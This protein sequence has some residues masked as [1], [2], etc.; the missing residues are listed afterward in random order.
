MTPQRYLLSLTVLS[1]VGVTGCGDEPSKQFADA[2]PNVDARL[3]DAALDAPAAGVVKAVS[4]RFGEIVPGATVIFQNA[5][6]STISTKTTDANG[7]ATETMLPG[8]TVNIVLEQ[9]F[10]KRKTVAFGGP[11]NE[12]ISFVG[13]KPGDV[14]RSG[15]LFAVAPM[16]S[17]QINLPTV[18][19]VS[20]I[21]IATSCGNAFL[22]NEPPFLIDLE[23]GC[24]TANMLVVMR[25]AN[26]GTLG[27]F[28]KG[29]VTIPASGA[30]EL[31]TEPLLADSTFN[32]SATNV[33]ADINSLNMYIARSAGRIEGATDNAFFQP[34]TV[35][36]TNTG[37]VQIYGATAPD[38]LAQTNY[39][40]ANG[41]FQQL[42][43]LVAPSTAYALDFAG[44]VLPW[45]DSQP[46][47]NL[48]TSEVTWTES[49]GAAP[50]AIQFR[51]TTFRQAAGFSFARTVIAPYQ[52][53]SLKI[54][55][56]PGPAAKY[57]FIADDNP[58]L[59]VAL[60]KVG[61]GYDVLRPL[62]AHPFDRSTLQGQRGRARVSY[63]NFGE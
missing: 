11:T 5:D 8:G 17:H 34:E 28:Y 61:V 7:E 22:I 18:P 3:G 63:S 32:V 47:L 60:I 45:F 57:D 15:D 38:L 55:K 56:L 39:F 30:I 19:G 35:A 10:T 2:N 12:V 13:V 46:A 59:G 20:R 48:A 41:G 51:A 53:G 36:A 25:D 21:E 49:A 4:I 9:T 1:L 16:M 43:E 52:L 24:T 33:P 27:T 6:G 26:N 42:V 37:T 44:Q 29:N 14:L 58:N 23:T 31:S 40:R 62:L 50:E 54:P